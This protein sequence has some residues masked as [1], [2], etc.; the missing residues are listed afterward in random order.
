MY[1]VFTIPYVVAI[2]TLKF[3][4]RSAFLVGGLQ[5]IAMEVDVQMASLHIA[6]VS[7]ATFSR[8]R[9]LCMRSMSSGKVNSST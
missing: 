8:L 7:L 4:I 6:R 3:V 2:M 5:L 9:S 1:T